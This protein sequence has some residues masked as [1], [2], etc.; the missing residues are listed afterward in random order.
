M[1]ICRR[2]DPLPVELIVRGYLAGSG[3]ADYQATGAIGGIVLPGG[4]REGDRLPEPILTPSTKAQSGHD[5]NIGLDDLVGLVG[6][7][8]AERAGAIALGLY[9]LGAAHAERAGILL[10]DTKFELGVLPA[11]DGEDPD[12]PAGRAERMLLVDEVLTPDSS[13]FWEAA[14]WRPGGPQPSF[15]KQYVRDWLLASGWDR[16]PP[17]PELPA[18]VVAGTRERYLAAFGRLTGSPFERYLATDRVGG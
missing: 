14:D 3:W 17:G 11:P 13:R 9:R 15:D 7:P 1:M 12:D 4:L 8:V 2:A 6:G 10:A 18:D 16:M 5:Q